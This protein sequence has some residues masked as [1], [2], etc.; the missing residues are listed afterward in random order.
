MSIC[1]HLKQLPNQKFKCG[2]SNNHITYSNC[3]D[4]PSFDKKE[5]KRYIYAPKKECSL[6]RTKKPLKQVS[7][8]REFVKKETYNQTMIKCKSRCVLCGTSQQLQLHHI[9]GRGKNK[10]NNID[11]CVMLCMDCHHN[12]VHKNNKYWREQLS[13]MEF[14]A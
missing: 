1:K 11:N 8:K 13:N 5:P 10:T 12:V 14:R 2:L 7:K 3:I 4:C 9:C 6:K